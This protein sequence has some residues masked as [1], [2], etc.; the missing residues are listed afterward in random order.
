MRSCAGQNSGNVIELWK[1]VLGTRFFRY[2]SAEVNGEDL[3][4]GFYG[5]GEALFTGS[6]P[7]T[8]A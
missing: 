5:L 3:G 6:T 2:V 1:F 8:K 4:R 7:A